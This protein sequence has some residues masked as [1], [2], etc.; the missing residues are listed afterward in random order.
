KQIMVLGCNYHHS[1]AF[2]RSAFDP[3]LV[4][5]VSAILGPDVELFMHG[6]CLYKEPVGGHPKKLHQDS[7]YFEHKYEGPCGVLTY[8]VDTDL[9]NGALHVVPGSHRLG[10][11][12]HIDTFSHLGL[13]EDEWPWERA[14]P[15]C[16][17]PGDAIFFHVRTIHGSKENNSNSARPVFIHRYRLA[18]DYVVIGGTTTENR[19]AN[20]QRAAEARK[21]NQLGLMVCGRRRYDSG[22]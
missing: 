12:K 3:K 20:E 19:A 14:L 15:I 7:A 2:F 9:V 18:D 5:L 1:A 13:D 8:L 11:L 6:Q 17:G 22:R 4:G 10:Q 16:G 21:E